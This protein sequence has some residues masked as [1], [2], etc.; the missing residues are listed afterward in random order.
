MMSPGIA[1]NDLRPDYQIRAD[2]HTRNC[3][4]AAGTL[5]TIGVL[6]GIA[7]TLILRAHG[8][9][10]STRIIP[11]AAGLGLAVVGGGVAL[12]FRHYVKHI[13]DHYVREERDDF[14]SERYDETKLTHSIRK[15]NHFWLW[16]CL[17]LGAN[18]DVK[19]KNLRSNEIQNWDHPLHLAVSNCDPES[20]RLLLHFGADRS[21]K[22]SLNLT[23]LGTASLSAPS[24]GELDVDTAYSNLILIKNLLNPNN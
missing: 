14:Y 3:V 1:Q 15:K 2:C 4:I 11:L 24:F 9:P 18:P 5:V 10:I 19:I 16:A 21:Q 23:P 12:S 20:V 6:G 17:V 13:N 8:H 22:N 7:A